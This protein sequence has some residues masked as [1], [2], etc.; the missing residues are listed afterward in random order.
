MATQKGAAAELLSEVK[1]GNQRL[2]DNY[3][4]LSQNERGVMLQLETTS[5]QL[6]AFATLMSSITVNSNRANR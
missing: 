1:R 5:P 4:Y 3:R 2:L 6:T